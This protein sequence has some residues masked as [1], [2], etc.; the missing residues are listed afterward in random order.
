MN[1]EAHH[2]C[3]QIL[4]FFLCICLGILNFREIGGGATENANLYYF[5]WGA[6]ISLVI[7][8]C[9]V[10]HDYFHE[11]CDFIERHPRLALWAL[12]FVS[13]IIVLSAACDVYHDDC[14]NNSN[15]SDSYCDRIVFGIVISVILALSIFIFVILLLTEGLESDKLMQIEA[16]GSVALCIICAL[17][18]AFLTKSNGPAASIG[19]LY[20]FTWILFFT[21]IFIFFDCFEKL[22]NN[23]S[24]EASNFD[25]GLTDS[26]LSL[27]LKDENDDTNINLEEKS[28]V[29]ES[30]YS[31]L[32]ES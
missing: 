2:L 6:L 24:A 28:D 17:L 11:P 26:S 21:A 8:W 23:S 18:V 25:D 4:F 31:L 15:H 20:Y 27:F 22:T 16:N 7:L 5:T 12:F 14:G 30:H 19:N 1:P 13:D 29:E 9:D 3:F 10:A 32:Q